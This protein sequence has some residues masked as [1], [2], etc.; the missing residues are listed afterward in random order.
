MEWRCSTLRVAWVMLYLKGA[1]NLRQILELLEAG[2]GLLSFPQ[3][4]IKESSSRAKAVSLH[5]LVAVIMVVKSVQ[6]QVQKAGPLV[7]GE[8][9]V[10]MAGPLVWGEQLVLVAEAAQWVQEFPNLEYQARPKEEEEAEFQLVPAVE[11]VRLLEFL[12]LVCLAVGEFH[13]KLGAQV[14]LLGV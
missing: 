11:V 6:L 14:A 12:I 8:Q 3:M 10:L 4:E 9:L 13:Q 5:Y 1:V 7:R 2:A